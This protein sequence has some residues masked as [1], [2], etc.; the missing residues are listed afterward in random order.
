MAEISFE[1]REDNCA[2][3][4]PLKDFT[5]ETQTIELRRDP[6]L[7]HTAVYNPL[8]EE[9]VKMFVGAADRELLERLRRETAPR[10]VF[11]PE[12]ID[13]VA[14]FDEDF[15]PGGRIE[16]GEAVLFPNLFALGRHHAVAAVSRAHFLELEE[17]TPQRLYDAFE[18]I[19][20][21]VRTVYARDPAADDVSVN[22][23][24][25]FPAGASIMHPHFQVLVTAG[26]YTHQARLL[27]ACRGYM[28]RQGTPYHADL[29][30]SERRIGQRYIG[31]TGHWDW[32][33][34]YA[35]MGSN[36]IL[37]I[38]ESSGD[39]TALEAADLQ[40]LAQGLSRVLRTYARLG[41]LAFNF[42]LYARREPT[43]PD[44][45]Q[46]LIRCMTRQNPYPDYRA[47]DFFLQ[48]GLQAELILNRPET[49]AQEARREFA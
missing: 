3:L 1:S 20:R 34:A 8:V 19:Q 38:H 12:R 48:K 30:R 45:F 22:A 35:P 15:I 11:C 13:G 31:E 28:A 5:P 4:N 27:T 26:P 23:N 16:V 46:C 6:L 43:T 17:F 47:D 9:G 37:G 18:A 36:E 49:L 32:L 2:L 40:G 42:S 44:G 29:V 39:L 10:C 33:A 25:L 41:Y 7:G 24:Y 14:R 21:Y